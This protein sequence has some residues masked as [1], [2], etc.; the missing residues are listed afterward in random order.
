MEG[1]VTPTALISYALWTIEGADNG[2]MLLTLPWVIYA[3]FKYQYLTEHGA[4][5]TPESTLLR[6]PHILGAVL[7][8][9]ATALFVLLVVPTLN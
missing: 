9:A 3:I 4:G 5:E 2:W 7:G 6:S 1:V 8:W